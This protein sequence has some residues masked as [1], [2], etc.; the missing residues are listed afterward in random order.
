MYKRQE[1]RPAF[2]VGV[3]MIPLLSLIAIYR[4][5]FRANKQIVKSQVPEYLIRPIL[6]MTTIGLLLWY[7]T[8]GRPVIAMLINVVATSIAV[9]FCLLSSRLKASDVEAIDPTSTPAKNTFPGY[10]KA[11]T[12]WLLGAFPFVVISGI[13]IINQRTDRLMLGALQDMESVGLYSVAVQMAMVVNFTLIGINQAIAPLVAERHDAN[14]GKELQKTLIQATNIATIGSLLIV[15]ALVLLGPI[16]LA[17]FG[18][19]FSA[20]YL[21]MIILAVGQLLNVASGPAGTILSMSRHERFVGIGMSISVVCNILLNYM[22]IPSYGVSGAA[23]ATALSV[24]IWNLLMVVFAKRHLGIDA[25]AG[26]V[27]IPNK[28][29]AE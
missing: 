2:V 22:L 7:A 13:A 18:P 11:S 15:A 4:G 1:L 20:S 26:A 12:T 29:Q 27:L 17:V 16:V 21:P 23:I 5:R 14:R 24:G 19:K 10:R 6:L 8:P 28:I 9:L 25:N 3:A